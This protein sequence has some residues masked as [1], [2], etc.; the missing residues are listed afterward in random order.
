MLAAKIIYA[1]KRV[2]GLKGVTCNVWPPLEFI[3]QTKRG[4]H[5]TWFTADSKLS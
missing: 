4:Q 5:I 3:C 2:I 1:V